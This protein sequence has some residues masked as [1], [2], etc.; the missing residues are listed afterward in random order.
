MLPYILLILWHFLMIVFGVL[1]RGSVA[2][3][4]LYFS[5]L[6]FSIIDIFLLLFLRQRKFLLIVLPYSFASWL[7]C[8]F[9]AIF[10]DKMQWYNYIDSPRL[11]NILKISFEIFYT[12]LNFGGR[13]F[14]F[15]VL[16]FVVF[17]VIKIFPC[18]IV[19]AAMKKHII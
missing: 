1:M 16:L 14:A 10:I 15:E 2:L 9:I 3:S 13:N 12:S 8:S 5:Y 7:L 6:G 18:S 19:L 17:L 11:I 4:A